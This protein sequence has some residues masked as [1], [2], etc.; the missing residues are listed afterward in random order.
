MIPRGYRTLKY[1][2]AITISKERL[3]SLLDYWGIGAFCSGKLDGIGYGNRYSKTMGPAPGWK[4]VVKLP[5]YPY[6]GYVGENNYIN[7]DNDVLFSTTI[8]VS[9]NVQL[10]GVGVDSNTYYL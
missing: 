8:H 1:D 5:K 4:F 7:A 2:E 9:N 6:Y 10:D 3:T